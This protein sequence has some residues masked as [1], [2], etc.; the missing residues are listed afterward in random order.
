MKTVLI[1]SQAFGRFLW[2]FIVGEDITLAVGVVLGL[3]A[4]AL[5]HGGG[6][7]SW[8]ALPV[9]WV[10]ALIISLRHATRKSGA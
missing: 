8:W 9:I 1:Q 5:L 4:V 6:I 2:K 7:V 10:V 3:L